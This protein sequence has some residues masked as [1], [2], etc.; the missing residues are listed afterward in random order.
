MFFPSTNSISFLLENILEF[1]VHKQ[2]Q[3]GTRRFSRK[4]PKKM[5][6]S[7]KLVCSYKMISVKVQLMH[8]SVTKDAEIHLQNFECSKCKVDLTECVYM[9]PPV[10]RIFL[11][12]FKA[13]LKVALCMSMSQLMRRQKFLIC[14]FVYAGETSIESEFSN[15]LKGCFRKSKSTSPPY[16]SQ[17]HVF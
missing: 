16:S 17:A 12:V 5:Q 1:Y 11:Q 2:N 8:E 14:V 7:C 6:P 4:N 10:K 13:S 9:T 3:R 15:G